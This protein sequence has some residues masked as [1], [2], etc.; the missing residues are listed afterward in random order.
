MI[1]L[2]LAFF[3]S[4]GLAENISIFYGKLVSITSTHY[5]LE[6]KDGSYYKIPRD[7]VTELEAERL[8]ALVNQQVELRVSVKAAKLHPKRRN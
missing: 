8:S 6:R 7:Q 4:L 5:E 1:A 2:V 3:A